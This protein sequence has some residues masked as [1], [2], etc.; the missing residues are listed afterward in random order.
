MRAEQSHVLDEFS[1][2]SDDR[3][4]S[5]PASNESNPIVPQLFVSEPHVPV[6]QELVARPSVPEES[7]ARESAPEAAGASLRLLYSP[8][9]VPMLVVLA[10]IGYGGLTVL[11]WERDRPQIGLSLSSTPLPTQSLR[12]TVSPAAIA[13]RPPRPPP[14]EAKTPVAA[15]AAAAAPAPSAHEGTSRATPRAVGGPAVVRATPASR[16]SEHRTAPALATNERAPSAPSPAVLP[17]PVDSAR[18]SPPLARPVPA[19]IAAAA[20]APETAAV[21]LPRLPEPSVVER[22]ATDRDAIG[23]VLRS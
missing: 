7:I 16:A 19:T 4:R 10:V 20:A 21:A 3:E 9:L 5:A 1:K 8:A 18:P 2:E 12:P 23:D 14:P 17:Q 13:P 22:V 15:A 6:A 11:W